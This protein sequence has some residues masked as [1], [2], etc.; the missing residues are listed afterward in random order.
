MVKS[1]FLE[2]PLLSVLLAL[3]EVSF[4]RPLVL[5]I[6]PFCNCITFLYYFFYYCGKCIGLLSS[7]VRLV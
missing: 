4:K 6:F 1:L 2:G 7:T 3:A 5:Y